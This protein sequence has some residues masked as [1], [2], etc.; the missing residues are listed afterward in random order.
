MLIRILT[1]STSGTAGNIAIDNVSITTTPI[2]RDAV[3]TYDEAGNRLSRTYEV[4][5][6]SIDDPLMAHVRSMPNK[7]NELSAEFFNVYPNP[8]IDH[9]I[10]ETSMDLN[11]DIRMSLFNYSGQL[12]NNQ[13]LNTPVSRIDLSQQNAGIY[14]LTV[15]SAEGVRN[16]KI[17]KN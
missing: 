15:Q 9:I 12:I 3:Y 11:R 7:P 17:V 6:M 16:W 1:T 2:L 4:T 5:T 13:S 10:L 14:I 8:A